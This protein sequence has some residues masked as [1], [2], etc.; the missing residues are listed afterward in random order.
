MAIQ[1]PP[2]AQ[3]QPNP[4]IP[5]GP[6]PAVFDKFQGINTTVT[7]P[8]VPDEQMAWAENFMPLGPNFLRAMWGIS[9]PLWTAPAGRVIETYTWANIGATAYCIVVLDNGSIYAI[10]GTTSVA[11]LIAAANTITT[12]TPANVGITQFGSSYIIIVARQTNGYFLWDGTSFYK[13]G[14]LGP[15]V[16]LTNIGAGYTSGAT[17]GV[18]G[19]SG[20]GATFV[21]TTDGNVVT[22]ITVSNP[23]TGY[24]AGD[25]VTLAISGTHSVQAT[26]TVT[27]M[28][29]AIGGTAVETY[30]GHVWVLNGPTVTYTA[31]GS[32]SNFAQADGG[33]NFTSSSSSL[34]VGYTQA[35]ATNGFLYLIA[36]SS[37]DYISGVQTSGSPP[38]TTF[39][40]QN[41]DPEVGTVWPN[42]VDVFGRNIVF[43]NSFGAHVSYGSA[44]T[45]ISEAL[46][47]VY[48]TVPL[49]DFGSFIPSAAKANIFGKK[50]WMFLLP[51]ID[52]IT[53]VQTNK[54]FLWNGKI[55]WP[56]SQ[57]VELTFIQH[58]EINS[59]LLAWGT[60]GSSLF[61]LFSQPSIAIPKIVQS[62]LYQIGGIFLTKTA[63]RLWVLSQ[64]FSIND[65]NLIISID[66]ERGVSTQVATLQPTGVTW[67]TAN[68]LPV[69]WFTQG[70]TPVTWFISGINPYDPI[71]V[72]QQGV[73]IGIT[74][75]TNC[76]DMA[77]IAMAMA[78]EI[79]DYRG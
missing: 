68:H 65:P 33:G 16:V 63:S 58:Q 23:G 28:P 61:K 31:P 70:G 42:T 41:A 73:L 11:T 39:S 64:Y 44:V 38:I 74:A 59:E 14:A 2:A 6:T 43:A 55:W 47:G 21:V 35:I 17:A 69:Q 46:D 25:V 72:G 19:G 57:D 4:Y 37:I 29:F 48:N 9:A 53:N 18:S 54:L 50:C 52:P 32:P 8:G 77:L 67:E 5:P 78:N 22:G 51:I 79:A 3:E 24:L 13:A 45:K 40:L 60:N 56:G 27:L 20:S 66:N 36:D 71:A 34:R 10:N 49:A 30:S 62:K 1:A 12:P 15:A 76:D 7:R 26:G 75:R